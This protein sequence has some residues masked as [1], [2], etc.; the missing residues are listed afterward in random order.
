MTT[1]SILGSSGLVD[2]DWLNM[3]DVNVNISVDIEPKTAQSL[4]NGAV[5]IGAIASATLLAFAWMPGGMA[6]IA[7][8]VPSR[9]APLAA[10]EPEQADPIV[11]GHVEP[12]QL[13]D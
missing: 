13:E 7:S 6:V 10:P 11:I 12:E 2:R 1:R 8:L 4:S 9:R 5:L 3:D